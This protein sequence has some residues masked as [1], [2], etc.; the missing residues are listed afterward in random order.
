MSPVTPMDTDKLKL[1]ARV[2]MGFE[3]LRM[4]VRVRWLMRNPD[5]SNAVGKLRAAPAGNES[6][7]F[8][9]GMELF[10]AWRVAHAT[11]GVLNRLPSDA[12]CLFRSLTL[13]GMLQR[14]GIAQTLVIAVRPEPFAAHAW[15]EVGGQ[16][17]LP[18]ADP[19][20]E[21]LMEL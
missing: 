21:R 1:G 7:G 4:Y 13:L 18:D 5:A 17:M 2:R 19:G 9:E 12:R 6:A 16:A 14:R 11:I 8:E 20:Y 3:V 15:I 10:V